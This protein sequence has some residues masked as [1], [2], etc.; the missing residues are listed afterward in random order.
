[1]RQAEALAR[2]G[3]AKTGAGGPRPIKPGTRGGKDADTRALEM[4]LSDALGMGVEIEDRDGRGVLT[5]RY[6]T[7]EQLD[8]LC[9]RLSR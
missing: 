3:E 5:I 8:E 9:R 4:D 6:A 1:V 7:L 2:G